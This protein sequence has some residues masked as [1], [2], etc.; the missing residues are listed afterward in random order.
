VFDEMAVPDREGNVL[1]WLPPTPDRLALRYQRGDHAALPDL[2]EALTPMLKGAIW[3]TARRGLPSALQPTDLEQQSWL[4][5]A[6][7]AERWQPRAGVPFAA[8]VAEA[9]PWALGRYVRAHSPARRSALYQVYSAPHDT[10]LERLAGTGEDD[11][12]DWD[13]QLYCRD[14]I[15]GLEPRARA[16][17]W[18]HAVEGRSFTEIA[19]LVGLPRATVYDLYR[20]ALAVARRAA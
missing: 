17:L 3:R 15:R 19:A 1:Y 7:L 11:G 9:F 12:R 6:A 18:L 16:V 10:L 5:L 13:E 4:L 14:L 2:Y 8:Y 20:R